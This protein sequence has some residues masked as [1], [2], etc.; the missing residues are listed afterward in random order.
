MICPIFIS[1]Q[2]LDYLARMSDGDARTALNCLQISIDSAEKDAIIS[3]VSIKEG[4]KRTHILYDR[5]GDE[6]FHCASALQKSIR[7]SND[8]AALYW[9]MRMLQVNSTAVEKKH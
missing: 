5:K 6:H 4:L 3:T 7:G 2:A 1:I 8:S 9:T